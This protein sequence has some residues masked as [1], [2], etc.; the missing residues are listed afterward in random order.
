MIVAKALEHAAGSGS[1]LDVGGKVVL[2][3]GAGCGLLAIAAA[4]LGASRV[5]A[6]DMRDM[7][8][9]LRRNIGTNCR[10]TTGD[11]VFV[12]DLTWGQPFSVQL[13]QKLKLGVDIVI[14]TDC[15][16]NEF[17][18]PPFIQSLVDIAVISGRPD[19]R[20]FVA[21]ELRSS[22]VTFE[23]LKQSLK[24]FE[25]EEVPRQ[26]LH[27]AFYPLCGFIFYRLRLRRRQE[28]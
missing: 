2:E 11:A 14:A 21:N 15:I 7:L 16:F 6:T 5:I 10:G 1:V 26:L 17:L 12:D 9:I 28:S 23:F 25:L 8:P 24:F 3:V 22:D 18:V 27:P 13:L 20:L 4:I 19:C